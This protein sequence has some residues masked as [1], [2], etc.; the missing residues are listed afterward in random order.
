MRRWF[1]ELLGTFLL[2]LVGGAAAS[3]DAL[4]GGGV[5]H[6]GVAAAFG[7]I[8]MVLIYTI[9]DVSGA[10]INPAVTISFWV[11][12]RF[13]GRQVL[14]YVVSQLAGGIGAAALLRPLFADQLQAAVAVSL[15]GGWG[16]FGVEAV[17][18]FVLMFVIIHVAQGAKEK[19]LMA[20]V[21]IGGAVGALALAFGPLTGASMN[22]A[23]ALGPAL[24][25]GEFSSL[26]AYML[27]PLLG[28]SLAVLS[29]LL[30]RSETCCRGIEKIG[31]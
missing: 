1:A 16:T 30:I 26:A 4:T 14:P 24:I 28:A 9:G 8:V 5:T 3:A 12:G 29:C 25:C 13:P 17:L 20:G 22:P 10:H 15:Y 27:A 7:V 21:A 31:G 2:V 18:S 19:G 23:R 11:A 6:V